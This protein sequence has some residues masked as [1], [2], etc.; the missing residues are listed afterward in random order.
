MPTLHIATRK[1]L[2]TLP[3]ASATAPVAW[4]AFAGEAVT[5]VLPVGD[6]LY[7]ALRLGHFGVK[8]HRSEDRGES[9]TELPAP[10]FPAGLDEAPAVDMIWTMVAAPLTGRLYAGTLPAALFQSDD[11]G[12]TWQLVE[13]LWQVPQR[14]DWQ[15][16]GYDLPGLHSILIDPREEANL[17]VAVS[18]GGVWRS[19]DGGASWT[20]VGDG[21]HADYM[22][23]A[24]AR[25][26]V[27]QDVHRL[28][29]CS[30]APETVWCQHH[31]GIFRSDDGGTTFERL[32]PVQ[33]SAFGFAV[34]AH[35]GDPATAWFVPAI[36]DECRIPVNARL[37]VTRTTDGGRTF[38]AIGRGLPETPCYDLIY[39]H[40]LAVSADGDVLAM[41]STTGNLWIGTAGGE[42][43]R[44]LEVHLP[45]IA[46]VVLAQ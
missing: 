18:T 35:P 25:D 36:K 30:A 34:A 37:A 39:R 44:R 28:A 9:W 21:L 8:L 31:N 46:Q 2:F 38:E 23:P 7:A 3:E 22:P 5:A 27:M 29:Q 17:T 10:A 20:L 33:P 13:S 40:G 16:G 26:L 45:P 24:L 14:K 12:E 19:A 43:W 6:R 32:D 11:G 4:P 1:G 41:G 15:G 42:Q